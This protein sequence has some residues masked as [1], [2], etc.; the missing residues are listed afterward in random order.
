MRFWNACTAMRGS[1]YRVFFISVLLWTPLAMAIS[2]PESSKSA[3]KKTPKAMKA[4]PPGA[5]GIEL[6]AMQPPP[7]Q[8]P[9]CP[10][11]GVTVTANVVALDQPFTLNRMG[12]AMPQGMIFALLEDIVPSSGST[13]TA[14][15]VVLRIDK[16]PRP[17]VLRMS[18]GDSMTV[19][20]WN[21]LSTKQVNSLQPVTRNAGVHAMGMQM[22]NQSTGGIANDGS[23]VGANTS[24]LVAPLSGSVTPASPQIT[25]TF[26]AQYEGTFLLYSTGATFGDQSGHSGQLAEGLFGAVNVA[27]PGGEAYRSQIT[28]QE[29]Q[30]ALPQ[31]G[32]KYS[33]VGQPLIDYQAHY[34]PGATINGRNVSCLP[35]LKIIDVPQ[36]YSAG[37]CSAPQGDPHIFYS[38]L[39]AIITGPNAGVFNGNGPWFQPIPPPNSTTSPNRTQPYRE[40]TIIYH[41]L[42]DAQQAFYNF[43]SPP[44]GQQNPWP[45][46][47]NVLGA[48]TDLFGINY[49]TGGIGAE[50]VANRLGV[51]PMWNC[52]ECKFEEFF[53]SA[54]AVG[55]PSMVVDVPANVPAAYI[56]NVGSNPNVVPPNS[57]E[58]QMENLNVN[59]SPL[60]STYTP[61][62]GAK[63]TLAYFADDPSNVY[64]SY[65]NDHVKFRILHAGSLLTHVHHQ[66]A[67]QWLH[68]P[69]DPNG[70][71][72]DSQLISPGSAFT[73]E[74]D[75]GGSGNRNKTLGDSIFH[76]HFYAHF[77]DGM[78]GMWRVH[79]VLE[80]GTQLDN[81]GRAT[82]N[83]RALPDGEISTGTPI[84]SIVPVPTQA[85]A[86]LPAYAHIV[87]GQINLQGTCQNN[88]VD[89]MQVVT[90]NQ[91]PFANGTCTNGQKY[92]GQVVNGNQFLIA[93]QMQ[94]PGYPFFIPGQ[95]G[96][97]PPH[98]PL[99]FACKT[100]GP[101]VGGK[102]TCLE[103]WDGGLPRHIITSGNVGL[104]RHNLWD[105][106][107]NNGYL[108]AVQLPEEG[109]AS[110]KAA[111]AYNGQRVHSSYT[112]NNQQASFIVN[113]LPNGPQSGAPFADPAVNDDGTPAGKNKR[114]YKAADIEMDAVFSKKGWHHPQERLI[115]LW[116]DVLNTIN[117][118]KAPEPFFFR[119]NSSDDVI[120]FWQTN[121]VP[122]YYQLDDFQVQTPTD[123]VGQHIHLVK[124]DVLASDGA[125]NGFNYEDGTFSPEEV[126]ARYAAIKAAGGKWNHCPGCAADLRPP[127][128][129]PNEI[130]PTYSCPANGPYQPWCG[131]QTT[132]QRWYPDLL[133]GCFWP[134][135]TSNNGDR[136]LRTVFT[137]DHF[138][139]ST[140]Q[141][142]GLYAGLL[143]EPQGS[144]WWSPDGKTQ[145]GTNPSPRTDGG[146]TSWEA[147]ILA[148]TN[149]SDSYR[150]FALEFQD[151][152]LTYEGTSTTTPVSYPTNPPPPENICDNAILKEPGA[153][154]CTKN[155]KPW[156][157]V[158]CAN[159]VNA[160]AL[161][162]PSVGSKDGSNC[163]S[164]EPL[165]KFQPQII[166]GNLGDGTAVMNYRNEPLQFRVYD[167]NCNQYGCSAGHNPSTAATDLSQAFSSLITRNDP[168]LN[169]SPPLGTPVN[170]NPPPTGSPCTYASPPA[171]PQ[172]SRVYPG[173]F[174]GANAGDPYTPLLRAYMNDRV[175]VRLLVG[176]HLA[177]HSYG[178]H[179]LKWYFEPSNSNSGY[180]DNQSMGIS[181]HF[182]LQFT[183]PPSVAPQ[184]DYLYGGFGLSDLSA[185]IWGLFRS[186]NMKAPGSQQP[187][188]LAA[189]PNNPNMGAT[190]PATAGCP[191][192]AGNPRQ[193]YAAAINVPG[194]L[195]YNS[196]VKGST[197][198]NAP[199]ALV[200]VQTDSYFNP[201][202]SGTPTEPLVLRANA[203]EC[204][205]VTLKNNFTTSNSLF[206]TADSNATATCIVQ[207]KGT[208][209]DPDCATSLFPSYNVGLHTQVVSYDVSAYDGMPVGTNQPI[210][211]TPT[212]V[213]P[214]GTATYSWYAGTVAA[215]GDGTTTGTPVEFGSVNLLTS[216]PM[217]QQPYAMVGALI[218]EPADASCTSDSKNPTNFPLTYCQAV[219]GSHLTAD[220]T[221]SSAGN[222]REFVS[223][224]QDNVYL[225]WT[226]NSD[227][228]T[229]SDS[230]NFTSN[231]MPYRFCGNSSGWNSVDIQGAFS[232]TPVSSDNPPENCPTSAQIINTDPPTVFQANVGTPVRFRMVH[233]DGYGGVPDNTITLHG[234]PWAEEPY[235]SNS[236]AIASNSSASNTNPNSQY[237]GSRDGFGPQN[238]FD[239]VVPKAGG[240]NGVCGDYLLESFHPQQFT[241]GAWGLFRV[242]GC[243][244]APPPKPFKMLAKRP[245][246]KAVVRPARK[247]A[248]PAER[249]LPRRPLKPVLG[250]TANPQD[251]SN[252][253]KKH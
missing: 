100:Q 115:T 104:E 197:I 96:H 186:Y 233:P 121:L 174:T 24:S 156:G 253:E 83:A 195:N 204:I 190:M 240:E 119:A 40:F 61:Q 142:A 13:L 163:A 198:G 140:H 170:Q 56:N 50:I 166:S 245:K 161:T 109:T 194:G 191:A 110:E 52:V 208:A 94:N 146:P 227:T 213:P 49:G 42:F 184:T 125:A 247:H 12:A 7:P 106:T 243:Q 126:Q 116:D 9:A 74:V 101:V 53:L 36:T 38:D 18:C 158:D 168:C 231:P 78:W 206:T 232:N 90:G 91:N 29:L 199:S 122:D 55:D 31:S 93:P 6:E 128:P 123:I 60:P 73:L 178:M 177:P 76:C 141:Q 224:L 183:S 131:A 201:L 62:A 222:F 176:A 153:G 32:P 30:Y 132:I 205:Q 43:F 200:Y 229:A 14:G 230:I 19:N 192:N 216:D 63:A 82:S 33:P 139:P 155:P 47:S 54:W 41:D 77:A 223:I 95:A 129:P 134:P 219:N 207:P 187:T 97:R 154:L 51:G 67:H 167:P 72:L 185:G 44:T 59:N 239:I 130:A 238:H 149:Q 11:S 66:H 157:W 127:Q 27:P 179:G 188:G 214:G 203:G 150:E 211:N 235:L 26:F 21:L 182:E 103:Q 70:S 99:D 4:V 237:L 172:D 114:V 108:N 17:L 58:A 88:Q 209:V 145:Y 25:Y 133:Q 84:P 45:D 5:G 16:R 48:G 37:T 159:A 151:L 111:M 212:P 244:G 57:W 118:K 135:C 164:Q 69:N 148:G 165:V 246:K 71:Y 189:L 138:G 196:T 39:T 180:R 143:V 218:I 225:Q 22:G 147:N 226:Q 160:P 173:P 3:P 242:S 112:P 102:P 20:F 251:K 228:L 215:N 89:G 136:T 241:N 175:Q 10:P 252:K 65:L 34:P 105:F 217:E 221:S 248:D 113:G 234:H 193:Y 124:F 81:K 137:H 75:Y 162:H 210:A 64:H 249:F 8:G 117:G 120:E 181:E 1:V 202:Q 92:Y 87:G 144:T 28:N 2:G 171:N 23:N 85:M 220:I 107:K 15:N 86:P 80:S 35:V 98:P 169:V 79:D 250:K 68:T 236:S 152:A 46:I